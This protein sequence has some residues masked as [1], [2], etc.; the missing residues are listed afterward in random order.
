MTYLMSKL[1]V[2]DPAGPM[3]AA[4]KHGLILLDE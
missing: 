1:N 3:R 2:H 4:I